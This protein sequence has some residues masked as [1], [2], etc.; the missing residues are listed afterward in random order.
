MSQQKVE[1]VCEASF[2]DDDVVEYL[3]RHPDFFD[4]HSDLLISL[5]VA[6]ETG[7]PAV[8]LV[9]RQVALFRQR[10]GALEQQLKDLVAAAKFNGVLGERIHRLSIQ[11]MAASGRAE[12]IEMLETQLREEFRAESAA[13]V[14]FAPSAEKIDVS[15]GF[16]KIVDRNDDRLKDFASFLK[17]ARPRCGLIRDR[18]KA[19]VFED[20]GGEINSAALVPL[21]SRAEL[22][23]LV[24]GSRDPDYFNPDKGT[25]FLSRLGELV[26]AALVG[27]PRQNAEVGS[28]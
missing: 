18:Q 20:N 25:D 5:R 8:S 3:Q 7:G 16:L 13:I 14:L 9:E 11:L 24:I 10:S 4:R 28:R 23:F 17:S 26:F 19:F 21:G 27:E 15:K 12:R 22:G 1:A 6:H 2:S